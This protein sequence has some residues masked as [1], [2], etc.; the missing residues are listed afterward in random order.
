MT[1]KG[2]GREAERKGTL[3]IV[4]MR[5]PYISQSVDIAVEVALEARRR[6][7]H[8]NLFLYLDGV[9]TSHLTK[10]KDYHNPGEWLRWCVKKGVQVSMCSRC[11]TARDLGESCTVPGVKYGQVW[12]DLT[13]MIDE[14]DKVLTFTE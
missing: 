10:D 9:F 6:G 7:H 13:K 12:G 1:E 11:S 8:V 14:A 3:T 2:K 4:V 5:G